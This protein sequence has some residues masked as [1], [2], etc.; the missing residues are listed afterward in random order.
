MTERRNIINLPRAVE[1]RRP[2][3]SVIMPARN[4]EPYIG[5]AIES[6][7]RQSYRSLELLVIDDGSVDRTSGVVRSFRDPRIRLY[8]NT[9]P[10]G[11]A[12]CRNL[13]LQMARGEVVAC[14]DADDI[15]HPRRL[16]RQLAELQAGEGPRIVGCWVERNVAG[17]SRIVRLPVAH[18]EIVAGF[19]RSLHRV[20]FV[21]GTML[22]PRSLAMAAPGRPR[23]RYFEDWDQLCRLEELGTAEFRNLPEVLYT[24][25]IR[26]KGSKGQPDWSRYNIFER[27]CRARRRSG[28]PEWTTAEDFESY[29]RQFPWRSMPW[30]VLQ[31]LLEVKV[32]LEMLPLRRRGLP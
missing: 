18:A 22:L 29:L 20:T 25:N 7:L 10:R 1:E 9:E 12:A 32:Q 23:F 31:M 16:E 24:Y 19:H 21:S 17:M 28:G 13:A 2:C 11:S 8:R 30:R 27:A 5:A 4:E 26:A 6:V 3:V 14:Q 15:S